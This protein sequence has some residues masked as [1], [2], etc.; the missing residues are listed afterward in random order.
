MKAS[1]GKWINLSEKRRDINN[2]NWT[3]WTIMPITCA[4][5]F[6]IFS[7][8]ISKDNY[9]NIYTPLQQ[10][11]EKNTQ[12]ECENTFWKGWA[13][14][15]VPGYN[16]DSHNKKDV[17][18]QAGKLMHTALMSDNASERFS[19]M[20]TLGQLTY[21]T[22]WQ[23]LPY[24][25]EKEI[26]RLMA[27]AQQLLDKKTTAGELM[28]QPLPMPKVPKPQSYRFW[29]YAPDVIIFSAGIIS[30]IY[31]RLSI[32]SASLYFS[33]Q[34]A[35]WLIIGNVG[36]I[37][38]AVADLIWLVIIGFI[39]LIWKCCQGEIHFSPGFI[40]YRTIRSLKT[41][42]RLHTDHAIRESHH[43]NRQVA[44]TIGS[45]K[46]QLR[47]TKFALAYNP[48]DSQALALQKVLE[49]AIEKF[50]LSLVDNKMVR[51]I[52][53][54]SKTLAAEVNQELDNAE[55]LRIKL[56]LDRRVDQ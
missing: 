29:M 23:F 2:V 10:A 35:W 16:P 37:L 31:T 54:D 14:L 49:E 53:S 22:T 41:Y 40:Y 12:I 9:D 38:V 8:L 1:S 36:T 24:I 47:Q 44:R 50:T 51:Q 21:E 3:I 30:A 56:E 6:G 4:S 19:A 26:P 42:L 20:Q 46:K 18:Y 32:G 48:E 25:P 33:R 28:Q 39:H 17:S 45:L 34:S 7:I 27:K 15:P 5:F 43:H 11:R 52:A 55:R 13:G